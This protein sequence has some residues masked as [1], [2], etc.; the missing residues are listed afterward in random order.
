MNIDFE[1]RVVY[2]LGGIIS[3]LVFCVDEIPHRATKVFA[4]KSFHTVGGIAGNA[5]RAIRKLDARA[6]LIGAIG[7]DSVGRSIVDAMMAEGVDVSAV[8]RAQG[9][10]GRSAI[11]LGRDGERLIVVAAPVGPELTLEDVRG[12]ECEDGH[13]LLADWR[14]LDAAEYLLNAY[15][16]AG[17]PAVLDADVGTGPVSDRLVQAATHVVFSRD[18]LAQFT[19]EAD[20]CDGLSQSAR[21]TMAM[22]G[23]TDSAN[24]CHVFDRNTGAIISIPAPRMIAVDTIGAGDVFHGAFTLA[25]GAGLPDRIAAH[26]ACVV[27]ASKVQGYGLSTLMSSERAMAQVRL[28]NPECPCF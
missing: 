26:Y 15:R 14:W 13:A 1:S 10:S 9:T 4:S 17:K 22:V 23:V 8:K 16:R 18:G 12:I 25:L 6:R 5:A 20:L 19:G 28:D 21:R 2:C 27:A 7:D 11:V 3:D 24:G